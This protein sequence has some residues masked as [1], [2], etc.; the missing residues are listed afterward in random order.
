MY[1]GWDAS[2]LLDYIDDTTVNLVQKLCSEELTIETT[3]SQTMKE[4]GPDPTYSAI[5]RYYP[6]ESGK[7][8]LEQLIK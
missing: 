6:Q 2:V 1:I 5:L 8:T 3:V 4:K 7:K